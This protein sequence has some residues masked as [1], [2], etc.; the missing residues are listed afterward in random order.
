MYQVLRMVIAFAL[1]Q[2]FGRRHSNTYAL[3]RLTSR[4]LVRLL[5]CIRNL[6]RTLSG[7]WVYHVLLSSGRY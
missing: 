3:I 4:S 1:R 7:P 5:I 2:L 6:G